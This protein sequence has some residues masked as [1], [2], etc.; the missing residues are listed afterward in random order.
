RR[1]LP[2]CDGLRALAQARGALSRSA[3]RSDS[4]R[5]SLS[6]ELEVDREL[7]RVRS[8]AAASQPQPWWPFLLASLSRL[9]PAEPPAVGLSPA[10]GLS[11]RESGAAAHA[12][13]PRSSAAQP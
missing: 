9:L 5:V 2:V 12:P 4:G 3:R 6:L 1:D 13:S 11:A 8:R 7:R 10:A